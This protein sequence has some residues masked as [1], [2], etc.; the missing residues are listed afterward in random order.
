MAAF[1][2]PASICWVRADALRIGIMHESAPKKESEST[3]EVAFQQLDNSQF[4]P[5]LDSKLFEHE[6]H[7]LFP[8]V[9]GKSI[10]EG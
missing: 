2:S 7:T 9:K 5:F 8:A 1:A 10:A 6:M 4:F 3:I